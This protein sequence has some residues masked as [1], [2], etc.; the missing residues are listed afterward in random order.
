MASRHGRRTAAARGAF[1]VPVRRLSR[2]VRRGV[3]LAAAFV[4]LTGVARPQATTDGGRA[5]TLTIERYPEDWTHL[6]DPDRRSG[7]WTERFKYIPLSV[8]GSAYL[9]TGM[10]FRSRYEHY[11]SANWGAAPDDGYIWHRFMPYA[12]LLQTSPGCGVMGPSVEWRSRVGLQG[13][14]L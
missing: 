13:T 9:T 1:P 14:P 7:R 2:T 4:A 8:D 11:G 3:V 6:A 5:P 10:E 12:A